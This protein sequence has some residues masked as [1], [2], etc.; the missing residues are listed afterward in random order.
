M[1]K[2]GGNE[3][4]GKVLSEW[5]A[6]ATKNEGKKLKALLDSFG[7]ESSQYY[8]RIVDNIE[9]LDKLLKAKK[10]QFARP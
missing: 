4:A 9:Q 1:W 8:Q 10:L 6:K 5:K 3:Y 7:F 2:K